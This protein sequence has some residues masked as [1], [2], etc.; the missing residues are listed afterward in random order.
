MN[1][2]FLV[3]GVGEAFHGEVYTFLLP[4]LIFLAFGN[5]HLSSHTRTQAKANVKTIDIAFYRMISGT[6]KSP[7]L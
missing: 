5:K 6:H 7:N 1:V 4:L 3:I 2:W